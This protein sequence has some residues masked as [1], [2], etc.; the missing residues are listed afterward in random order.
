MNMPEG[1]MP[2]GIKPEGRPGIPMWKLERYLLGE[3]PAEEMAR[4]AAQ[5]KSDPAVL[6]WLG[7]LRA[8]YRDLEAQHPTGRVAGRIWNKLR[9]ESPPRAKARMPMR[10]WAP[11]LAVFVALAALPFRYAPWLQASGPAVRETDA[12]VRLK[13]S[14]PALA[15]YKKSGDNAQRLSPGERVHPGD[16]VQIYYDAAGKGYGAIFSVDRAGRITWHLPDGGGRSAPLGAP[17]GSA[18]GSTSPAPAPAESMQGG[19]IPLGFA[20][21]LD[22]LPGYERFYFIAA[23]K[24]FAFDSALAGVLERLQA[25]RAGAEGLPPL[26]AGFSQ[27]TFSLLKEQGI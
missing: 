11:A 10:Y 24:P 23:D 5:E 17:A 22:S 15:L 16:V 8:E 7:A 21:E 14:Q 20:F 27:A 4:I 18:D 13:G 26:P 9:L 12:G 3:L 25:A 19:K 1:N 2:E 6:E